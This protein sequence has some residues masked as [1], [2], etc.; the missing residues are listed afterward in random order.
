VLAADPLPA[1]A[2]LAVMALGIL[3]AIGGHVVASAR[4]VGFG[5]ALVFLATALMVLGGF[6]AYEGR[7]R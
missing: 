3:I 5:L 2:V 1:S 7:E 4:V 6:A